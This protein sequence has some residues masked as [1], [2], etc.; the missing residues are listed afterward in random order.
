L[1]E[2]FATKASRAEYLHAVV[3]LLQ[4]RC[5]CRGVAIRLV[6]GQGRL[7]FAAHSGLCREFLRAERCLS[8]QPAGCACMRTLLNIREPELAACYGE[9]GSFFCNNTPQFAQQLQGLDPAEPPLACLNSGYQSSAVA[10]IRHRGEF[11]GIVQLAD[12]RPSR[13]SE[14]IRNFIHSVT[15]LLGEALHRFTM[16]ESLKESEER[17]RGMFE[18]HEA[19]MLLVDP[20]KSQVVEANGA[21][22]SFF[23][24]PQDRLR[25]L[26]LEELQMRFPGLSGSSRR[27]PGWDTA[28]QFETSAR[29]SSGELRMLE[30][31]ASLISVQGE[32]RLFA[33]VHDVTERKRL[34]KRIL[35]IGDAERR[36]IGRDLHDSL[37]GHLTGIALLGK[38]LAQSLS[39]HAA[40]EADI[41]AEVVQGI[42]DAIAQTRLISQGLCP[43][44][45]GE[46]G[47]LNGLQLL[48]EDVRRRARIDCQFQPGTGRG[49]RDPFVA[50]H[51][52]RI[53]QEAVTNALRHAQPTRIVIGLAAVRGGE[54]LTI[55]NDGKP[56]P[57]TTVT[58]L[59]LGM[60]T[61]QFRAT[62]V[63]AELSIERLDKGGGTLVS[64]VLP[65]AREAA[66]PNPGGTGM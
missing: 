32:P 25:T 36:N 56:L 53:A 63:G 14:D 8:L 58:R 15:P 5:D 60:Q 21:A 62:T 46:H 52:F 40:P 3:K 6:T 10:A 28:R 64:C 27:R 59:G 29:L 26:H 19:P 65:A 31:H 22:A 13:F 48:A 61:M 43:V 55:W 45:A 18:K 37:G 39:G 57:E 9:A 20:A 2:L 38:A 16:E 17:F 51:L 4:R 1:L 24:Y 42:N 54:A 47:L 66:A 44:E 7:P 33:I 41:A 34:E 23:G 49:P 50:E 11:V 35:E 30:V 12:P